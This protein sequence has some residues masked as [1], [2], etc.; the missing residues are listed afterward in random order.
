[1]LVT[2]TGLVGAS[3]SRRLG[4]ELDPDGRILV[5][6]TLQAL[7]NPRVLAVGDC[8]VMQGN[9]RPPV[10]VFGVRGGPVLVRNLMAL[11]KSRNLIAY[12][13][14]RRWLFIMDLGD[15]TGIAVWGGAG[16]RL[17]KLWT[18]RSVPVRR[19]F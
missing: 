6:E 2:A 1:M 7:S 5:E 16:G 11:V 10:G 17:N 8:A 18:K 4:F 12:R 3:L 19:G 13:P 15:G 14:Q 9:Q